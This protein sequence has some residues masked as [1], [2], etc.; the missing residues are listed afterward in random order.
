MIKKLL[1]V[2]VAGSISIATLNADTTTIAKDGMGDFLIAPLY[3]ASKDICSS[4]KVFNTNETSSILAKVTFREH[5]SSQEVDFPIFLSP[6]DVWDG[7]V[8][9]TGSTVILKSNDDS[10]HPAIKDVLSRGKDLTEQSLLSGHSNVDFTRGYIE[11]YPIA[12]FNE[13]SKAKV[14]KSTLVNRWDRLIKGDTSIAKLEKTGVD[15]YSLSA[16]VS[17]S[18][19]GETTTTLPMLAFKGAH[20]KQVTG[21]AIAYSNDTSPELLLGTDK[22]NAI[23]KLLQHKKTSFTY[24]NSGVNQFISFTFPFSYKTNQ[25]RTYEITVRDMSEN[26]DMK[27]EEVIIFSPAPIKKEKIN[28]LSNEVAIASIAELISLTNNPRMFK[29]GM[30]QIKEITNNNEVQ[31]GRGQIA[32]YIPVKFSNLALTSNNSKNEYTVLVNTLYVPSK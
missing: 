10:N 24:E 3:I 9:E 21:S 22:K 11:I 13:N 14:P 23:L 1:T 31:L 17:F 19:N 15:G 28:I 32:S 12:Q 30:I 2:A 29:K 27:K 8:C 26:K 25:L 18:S 20:N 6:G 16:T 5:I 7:E 4:I